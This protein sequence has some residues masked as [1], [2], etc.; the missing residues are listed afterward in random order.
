M[1]AEAVG[2]IISPIE[3]V[4]RV[5]RMKY[6]GHIERMDDSRLPKIILHSEMFGG[7]RPSGSPGIVWRGVMKGDMQKMGIC[8]SNWQDLAKNK[9]KWRRA[10]T[11]TGRA[12]LLKG[13]Y[14]ARRV[15]QV[16]RHLQK[17]P[18]AKEYR[19]NSEKEMRC[20]ALLADSM[21]FRA[22]TRAMS[23]G[24]IKLRK[25]QKEQIKSLRSGK[26]ITKTSIRLE[27]AKL[28]GCLD[29]FQVGEGMVTALERAGDVDGK[30][31]EGV[32]EW[33]SKTKA[34]VTSGGRQKHSRDISDEVVWV[35]C[36]LQLTAE[37]EELEAL[38]AGSGFY[39]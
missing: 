21:K 30:F 11:V 3:V 22:I 38:L 12:L 31:V 17:T 8:T 35:D 1:L 18:K 16:K 23:A 5:A 7:Q 29:A 6:L 26:G 13:W 19:E 25:K 32:I 2:V 10:V 27:V 4:I 33:K 20:S 34:A 39:D 9:S 28:L 24:S 14:E 15:Q 37:E 36:A